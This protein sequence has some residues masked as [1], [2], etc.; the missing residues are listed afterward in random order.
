MQDHEIVLQCTEKHERNFYCDVCAR[1]SCD[2]KQIWDTLHRHCSASMDVKK[3]PQNH[4]SHLHRNSEGSHKA[5]HIWR[6]KTACARYRHKGTLFLWLKQSFSLMSFLQ[7]LFLL[8]HL[9]HIIPLTQK[10]TC[11]HWQFNDFYPLNNLYSVPIDNKGPKTLSVPF[12]VFSFLGSK[13][14]YRM[15]LTTCT[16]A[17]TRIYTQEVGLIFSTCCQCPLCDIYRNMGTCVIGKPDCGFEVDSWLHAVSSKT[18]FGMLSSHC[19]ILKNNSL[20]T[21]IIQKTYKQILSLTC[22]QQH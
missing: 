22:S 19:L 6:G 3:K 11:L 17:G 14:V 8:H 16:H 7:L 13:L 5:A 18:S 2:M 12:I 15:F 20:S 10:A 21:D 4:L 1:I 9:V